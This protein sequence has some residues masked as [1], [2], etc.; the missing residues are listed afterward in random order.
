[1]YICEVGNYIHSMEY[2]WTDYITIAFNLF[3][4]SDAIWSFKVIQLD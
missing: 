1:M 4:P 3:C 2:A